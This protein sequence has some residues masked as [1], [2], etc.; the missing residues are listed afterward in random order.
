MADADVA[1][2]RILAL[3]DVVPSKSN[4]LRSFPKPRFLRE[5]H[6]GLTVFVDGGGP[7]LVEAEL[8]AEFA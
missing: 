8:D 7:V 1:Y 6:R 2:G 3:G 4:V 5:G